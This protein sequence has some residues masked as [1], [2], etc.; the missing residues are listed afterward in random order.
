MEE[1]LTNGY[2]PV[3]DGKQSYDA[4]NNFRNGLLDL[5]DCIQ[6]REKSTASSLPNFSLLDP[7]N[8]PFYTFI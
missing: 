4:V 2:F 5:S 1:H 8:L 3:T 7:Q 6:K